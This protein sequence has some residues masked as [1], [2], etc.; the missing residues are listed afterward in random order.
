MSSKSVKIRKTNPEVFPPH[1]K[2]HVY[3]NKTHPQASAPGQE[4]A[5]F[6]QETEKNLTDLDL[7][8]TQRTRVMDW[9]GLCKISNKFQKV[10]ILFFQ[11][12]KL[13]AGF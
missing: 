13:N 5:Q 4:M 10:F 11:I 2:H 1:F 12:P 6:K 7:T 9:V 8:E 3:K